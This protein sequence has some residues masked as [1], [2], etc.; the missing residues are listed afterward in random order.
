MA[1]QSGVYNTTNFTTDLAKKSFAGMITRLMPNGS[2][3]LYAMT[4]MMKDEVAAQ[5]EHGYFSKTMVFPQITLG[6]AVADGVATA[7]TV[8]SSTGIVPGMLFRHETT[9]EQILVTAVGGPTSV[10][11]RRAV[12]TVAGAAMSNSTRLFQ[13][14]NAYE[15]G[16][17]RPI[18][19]HIL[20][21]RFTN[22][23]QIFRNSW[24]LTDTVRATLV[25]AGEST[26]A[27]SKADC[28]AFHATDIEK[29]IFF[30][31]KYMGTLNN[32]PLHTMDG[33]INITTTAAAAN[34]T[35]LAATTNWTQFEAAVDPWFNQVTD[36]KTGNSR[37]L[38]VGGV[39]KRVINNICRLNSTYFVQQNENS[40]G[41]KFDEIYT[42]RGMLTMV[43]HPL[44]NSNNVWS[45][46]AVGVDVATFAIAY[47]GNRRTQHRTYN[48]A[49]QA[50][51]V[52]NGVDSV[53]GTLTTELTMLEKNPA[54]NGILYNFTAAAA[55]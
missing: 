48:D 33:L 49:G 21:D 9:F 35:T 10:T 16:S 8:T 4:S 13:S 37:T 51:P 40:W 45:K 53:G 42:A 12:G 44:F 11:V 14:G 26:V 23:T 17:A 47:L 20:A 50:I 27:E 38:F 32:Q 7:F 54:A 1:V 46:M 24:A 5:I 15:E 52:D 2:A 29:A 55:G 6:A 28:A 34:I 3:P 18:A 30:G 19:V 36:P 39:A 43:E 41:L 25:I 22:Y 31:Q